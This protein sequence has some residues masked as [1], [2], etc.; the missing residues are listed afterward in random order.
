MYKLFSDGGSRSNPGLSATGCIIFNK[1]NLLIDFSS[2]FLGISTNNEAEYKAL[3]EGIQLAIKKDIKELTCY[4]DS[5]LVVK[6]LNGLYKINKS[7][8]KILNSEI[9]R[10][11]ENFTTLTFNHIPR[12]DNAFA[13]KLVNIILDSVTKK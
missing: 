13:D 8:L 2:T 7:E 6:Q 3:H 5:E 1:D 11:K 9:I 4:L 10:L 12:K